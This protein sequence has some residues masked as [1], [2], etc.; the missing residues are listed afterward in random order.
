MGV[1][2]LMSSDDY[3]PDRFNKWLG[4]QDNDFLMSRA[5]EYGDYRAKAH[6][7]LFKGDSFEEWLQ[8]WYIEHHL[9]CGI[10]CD[11]EYER[12]RDMQAEEVKQ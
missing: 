2:G 11:A 4:G 9:H 5:Q 6:N 10:D 1:S 7:A 8:E 3:D 12:M